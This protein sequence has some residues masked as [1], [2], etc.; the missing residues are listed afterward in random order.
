MALPVAV[1][2][3]GAGVADGAGVGSD[4]VCVASVSARV[5]ARS[6]RRR[7]GSLLGATCEEDTADAADAAVA[8]DDTEAVEA[9][10]RDVSHAFL[11]ACISACAASRPPSPVD[12]CCCC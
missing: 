3:G 4:A 5:G 12:P 2:G 8:K 9:C 7:L 6:L 1:A 10:V 11:I